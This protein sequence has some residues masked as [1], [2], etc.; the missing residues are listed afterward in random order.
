MNKKK[1]LVVAAHPDD[2]VLGCGGTM[3]RLAEEGH[4]VHVLIL[5]E[6]LTSREIQRDRESK[7]SELNLLSDDANK[8]NLLLGVKTIELYDFP[9]NR[10]DSIDRL[11]VIKVVERKI[12]DIKPS[13]LFTHFGNDLNIDHRI[14]NEAVVTACRAYPNQKV[15]ELFFFEV[16]SSTEWQISPNLG[17]F[18]PNVF[19]KLSFQQMEK[20]KN[21]LSIYESEMRPFPHARS[22]DAVEA[23]GK[24]RGANIGY[25]Y[26]EAFV[27]GRLI[28]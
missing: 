17:S 14:T 13:I 20:K 10:M 26:A 24:W 19:F 9:D 1:V 22:I 27:C 6:G 7:L 21:A 28:Q 23:L 11:D 25:S 2:E 12:E 8:A 5:A 3:A 18:Q 15:E 4:E 16:A